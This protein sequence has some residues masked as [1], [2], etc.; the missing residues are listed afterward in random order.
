MIVSDIIPT[1]I[2]PEEISLASYAAAIAA[3]FRT[4][5][6]SAS[7]D[8]RPSKSH[9]HPAVR[10][11]IAII[12]PQIREL[13][14]EMADWSTINRVL[15]YTVGQIEKIWVEHVL[16]EE[17][18]VLSSNPSVISPRN[19]RQCSRW[20]PPPRAKPPPAGRAASAAIAALP[21][22]RTNSCRRIGNAVTYTN[23]HITELPERQ[24]VF[25]HRFPSNSPT[26]PEIRLSLP[27]DQFFC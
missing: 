18:S 20:F 16:P 25:R 2:P 4:L 1:T 14:K 5:N 24:A 13:G 9:P 12:W 23:V 6:P 17:G 8:F 22:Q 21:R 7:Q 11:C 19:W 3:L 27:L 15:S 10:S 26:N